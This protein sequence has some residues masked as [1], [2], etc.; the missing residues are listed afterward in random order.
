MKMTIEL[1]DEEILGLLETA[2][3]SDG[4]RYWARSTVS[5]ETCLKRPISV[6]DV[7]TG[8]LLGELTEEKVRGAATQ[9]A[10]M[11][12]EGKLRKDLFLQILEDPEAADADA[13]D[14]FVQAALFGKIVFS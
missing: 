3:G 11:F 12:H 1:T 6:F 8:E 9:M 4:C 10:A 7:E 5:L 13:A 14:C 2:S